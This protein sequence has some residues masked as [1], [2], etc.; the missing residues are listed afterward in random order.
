MAILNILKSN[1]IYFKIILILKL[2][3]LNK[4][5]IGKMPHQ[6]T[7]E[8]ATVEKKQYVTDI[9]SVHIYVRLEEYRSKTGWPGDWEQFKCQSLGIP[10]SFAW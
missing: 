4:E 3:Y 10:N 5:R 2:N 6:E 1:W 9:T 8:P 7:L